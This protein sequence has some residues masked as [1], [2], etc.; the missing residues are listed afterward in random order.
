[1][2]LC[3]C[4]SIEALKQRVSGR[5]GAAAVAELGEG[6]VADLRALLEAAGG[7]GPLATARER[8]RLQRAM[9]ALARRGP[10]GERAEALAAAKDAVLALAGTAPPQE[11]PGILFGA[12]ELLDAAPPLFSEGEVRALLCALDERGG[13][14]APAQ[15]VRLALA[16]GLT[17]AHVAALCP[18]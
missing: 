3:L 8:L 7:S 15:V 6:E 17:R 14:G 16:R 1:M 12:A 2:S 9:A 13:G 11:L 5:A 18:A 4:V 10:P